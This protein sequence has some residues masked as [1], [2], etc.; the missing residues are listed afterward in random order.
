MDARWH[1]VPFRRLEETERYRRSL[2]GWRRI[3]SAD[4]PDPRPGTHHPADLAKMLPAGHVEHGGQLA[5][6]AGNCS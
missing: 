1:P 2:T 3:S 5:R 6:S 4:D